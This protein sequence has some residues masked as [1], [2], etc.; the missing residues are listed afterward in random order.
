[1]SQPLAPGTKY[2]L[3]HLE[4]QT[5]S[6]IQEL[7]KIQQINFMRY[8]ETIQL[9]LWVNEVQASNH[10]GNTTLHYQD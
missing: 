2:G 1:M 10:L 4:E 9:R 8:M 6:E 3:F 5:Q 7:H